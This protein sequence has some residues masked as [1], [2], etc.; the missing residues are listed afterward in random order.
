[1]KWAEKVTPTPGEPQFVLVLCGT[2][3]LRDKGKG[4]TINVLHHIAEMFIVFN[5][6]LFHYL[7]LLSAVI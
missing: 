1:M 2:F 4:G 5:D 7:E 3:F 6:Q